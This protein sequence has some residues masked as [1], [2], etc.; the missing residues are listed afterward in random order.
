MFT[1]PEAVPQ[2]CA[3]LAIRAPSKA[4]MAPPPPAP[5]NTSATTSS[6][7]GNVPGQRTSTAHTSTTAVDNPRV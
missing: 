5:M 2:R 6:G 1:T 3:A 4:S 7:I